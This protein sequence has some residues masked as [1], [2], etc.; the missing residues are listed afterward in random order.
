MVKATV[1]GVFEDL[2]LKISEGSDQNWSCPE[3][4]MLAVSAYLDTKLGETPNV[5]VWEIVVHIVTM[6]RIIC[7]CKSM[8]KEGT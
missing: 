2:K 8:C 7:H 5:H 4:A 1:S 3:S 6:V